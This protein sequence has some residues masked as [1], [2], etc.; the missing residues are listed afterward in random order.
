MD[1]SFSNMEAKKICFI[2]LGLIPL[3]HLLSGPPS[4]ITIR[5][6]VLVN[7]QSF[8]VLRGGSGSRKEGKEAEEKEEGTSRYGGYGYGGRILFD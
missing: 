4:T 8:D 5:T 6:M 3:L 1:H 2:S 7:H